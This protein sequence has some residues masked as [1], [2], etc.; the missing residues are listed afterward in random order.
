MIFMS[1]VTLLMQM[2]GAQCSTNSA[3]TQVI[4]GSTAQLSCVDTVQQQD[5]INNGDTLQVVLFYRGDDLMK[6]GTTSL[7]MICRTFSFLFL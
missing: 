7:I 6:P 3:K 2:E 4:Q 1:L 5:S